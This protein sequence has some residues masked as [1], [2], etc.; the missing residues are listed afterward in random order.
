MTRAAAAKTDAPV[1]TLEREFAHP[2]DAVFRAWTDA[3]ALARWMG[4]GEVTCAG[5]E[6]DAREGGAY[7]FPMLTS[8]GTSH[9]VRG[10]ILE[11]VPN[12]RLRFTWAWDQETGGSGQLME[13]TVD[14]EPTETGTR[15]VLHQTNFIDAEARDKHAHGWSGSLD[16]LERHLA[17]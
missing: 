12:R 10:T 13:V 3:D 11:L 15:L 4:P 17:G 8:D 2:P 1:L 16:K 7:A 14:V 6:M 5:A 9:T